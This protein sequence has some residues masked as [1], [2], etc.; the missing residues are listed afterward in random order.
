VAPDL[1]NFQGLLLDSL[2]DPIDGVN[3]D[4]IVRIYP[5]EFSSANL[6]Y[7]EEHNVAVVDGVFQIAI[8]AGSFPSGS[9]D[10]TIFSGEERWLEIEVDTEILAPRQRMMSMPYALQA[11]QCFNSDLL[12]GQS[13]AA[14]VSQ[15]QTGAL[16]QSDLDTHTAD[17]AAHHAKTTSFSELVDVA[18]DAQIPDAMTR[19]TELGGHAADASAHHAKTTTFG[20]LSGQASDA[21]IPGLITRDVEVMPLVLLA[22]GATSGLD[23]DLLDGVSSASFLRSDAADTFTGGT[24]AFNVGTNLQTNGALNFTGANLIVTLGD[25][26]ADT[27]RVNGDLEMLG[28]SFE[29]QTGSDVA[30]LV[31]PSNA[32]V[33]L[34]WGTTTVAGNDGDVIVKAR[35]G[36]NTVEISGDEG[37]DNGGQ[38]L[39]RNYAGDVTIEIDAEYGAGGSGRIVTEVLQITGGAD[40]SEG[41]QVRPPA[42]DG[43]YTVMPGAVVCIDS[44]QPGELRVCERAYDRTV[45]GVVS[46]AG[47]VAPGLLMGQEDS[48]ASGDFPVALSGRVYVRTHANEAAIEPGDL[49]TTSDVPGHAMRAS[50]G[51]QAQGAVLGKAMTRPDEA[52]LVLMLV[53][54]Q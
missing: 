54:L 28:G 42:A 27:T 1:V 23:A 5:D 4:V 34:G 33:N 49:L 35:N 32:A 2:G 14:I 53:S 51:S 19:D 7:Y 43:K 50:D 17:A 45:A 29:M 44:E 31:T 24:L 52:G 48:V 18:A 16:M 8:G 47:G 46:G 3:V 39:L 41:F 37:V 10:E 21:Q 36:Q 40:L 15:A 26:S 12:E 9:F 6:L 20:E 25:T 22:D 11:Q 30:M 38:V 13:V